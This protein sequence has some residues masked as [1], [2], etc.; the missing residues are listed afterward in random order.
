[1]SYPQIPAVYAGPLNR[2]K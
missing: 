2:S 1:M